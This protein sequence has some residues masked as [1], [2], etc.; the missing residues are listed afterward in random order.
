[1]ELKQ[2]SRRWVSVSEA[3]DATGIPKD[4]IRYWCR[5]GWIACSKRG[6]R[7]K[8]YI[9]LH[10]MLRTFEQSPSDFAT[11]ILVKKAFRQ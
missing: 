7:G 3:H 8:Y 4:T 1:M 5:K 11:E 6:G 9:D 10:A 2:S